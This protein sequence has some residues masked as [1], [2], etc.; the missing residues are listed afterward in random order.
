MSG[1][2]LLLLAFPVA[3][4]VSAVWAFKK[5]WPNPPES[6]PVPASALGGSRQLTTGQIARGVFWGLWLFVLSQAILIAIFMF[7]ALAITG[8]A[9]NSLF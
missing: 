8:S 3:V 4:I 2:E 5:L 9:M 6:S 7:L 1:V